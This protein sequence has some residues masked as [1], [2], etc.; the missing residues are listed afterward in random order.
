MPRS[1]ISYINKDVLAL[2]ITLSLSVVLL[3][4][5]SS[6]QIHQLK[7]RISWLFGK[8]SYP[9]KWYKDIFSIQEENKMLKNKVVTECAGCYKLENNKEISP[10]QKANRE[11]KKHLNLLDKAIHNHLNEKTIKPVWYDLRTSNLCNLECQMCDAKSSSS[12]AKRQGINR[13]FLTWDIDTNINPE[14]V[15]VYLAGGEPFLIKSF[16]DRLNKITNMVMITV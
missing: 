2:F 6:P 15:R 16:S 13:P 5:N 9:V 7:F 4:S 3:F 1:R 14:S 11:W 8:V 12:I 10:R